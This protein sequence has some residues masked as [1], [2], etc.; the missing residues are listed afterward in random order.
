MYCG[1]FLVYFKNTAQ[2]IVNMRKT[3]IKFTFNAEV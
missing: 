2:L 3:E 1:S